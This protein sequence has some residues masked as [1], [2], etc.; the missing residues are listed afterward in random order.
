MTTHNP[1]VWVKDKAIWERAKRQVERYWERYDEPWAVVADV[2]KKMGGKQKNP[3]VGFTED[4][5]APVGT[6]T[7]VVKAL[8]EL[9]REEIESLPRAAFSED[10]WDQ[11]D[12][13]VQ[14]TIYKNDEESK[15][16]IQNLVDQFVSRHKWL[17]DP[18]ESY[19]RERLE[20]DLDYYF[21]EMSLDYIERHG[22]R[23]DQETV[24]DLFD[25]LKA[26]HFTTDQITQ[27]FDEALQDTSNWD[28]TYGTGEYDR[29]TIRMIDTDSFFYVDGSDLDEWLEGMFPDEVDLAIAEINNKTYLNIDADDLNRFY[30]G[31]GG[32]QHRREFESSE[33]VTYYGTG[34]PDW[35]KIEE[36]VRESLGGEEP[37][38]EEESYEDRIV[39]RYKDGWFVVDLLA[40][41]L[42]A[43]GRGRVLC[44]G[45]P[46]MGYIQAVEEG[47]NKIFSIRMPDNK[48]I[49]SVLGIVEDGKLRYI[50][51]IRT[52]RNRIPGTGDLDR[53]LEFLQQGLGIPWKKIKDIQDLKPA[54]RDK[55]LISGP[56]EN[57]DDEDESCPSCGG[58][59]GG[60]CSP[61]E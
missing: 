61:A 30:G 52:D 26:Q 31:R 24:K 49:W 41:E 22:S 5:F 17:E 12:D 16:R 43:E 1:P 51:Q 55:K 37:E 60:F 3:Q 48:R 50:R 36:A 7:P 33:Y 10:E 23:S 21:G 38:D 42:R 32:Q 9:S 13:D 40:S 35:N 20:S 11:L 8:D 18:G 34:D 19:V 47:R 56:K 6:L 57:P 25:E 46:S 45:D 54:L 29:G 14:E 2:Y 15:A 28:I 39:Y 53:V 59:P 4:M 27:A 58:P 44:M